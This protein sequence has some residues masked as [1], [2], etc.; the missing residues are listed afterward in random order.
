MYLLLVDQSSQK[1]YSEISRKANK[2]VSESRDRGVREIGI[3]KK[4][5]YPKGKMLR[6]MRCRIHGSGMQRTPTS[7]LSF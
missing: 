5:K 2:R 6:R 4:R 3:E 7:L 1:H